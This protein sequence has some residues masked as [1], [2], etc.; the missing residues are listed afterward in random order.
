VGTVSGQA[1]TAAWTTGGERG[2][3]APLRSSGIL[4]PCT[5]PASVIPVSVQSY[6]GY[7]SP[8]SRLLLAPWPLSP[9]QRATL[10]PPSFLLQYNSQH[11]SWLHGSKQGH[12]QPVWSLTMRA[13]EPSKLCSE[14]GL[15]RRYTHTVVRFARRLRLLARSSASPCYSRRLPFAPL[16]SLRVRF[17]KGPASGDS[18]LGKVVN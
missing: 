9:P 6:L 10:Q 18:R 11:I 8:P 15:F 13:R 14:A 16:V 4:H 3:R 1:A 17:G 5:P 7:R 12:T 2:C